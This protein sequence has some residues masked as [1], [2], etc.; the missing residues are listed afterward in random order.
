MRVSILSLLDVLRVISGVALLAVAAY[1]GWLS[2]ALLK[3]GPAGLVT[4]LWALAHD[5]KDRAGFGDVVAALAAGRTSVVVDPEFFVVTVPELTGLIEFVFIELVF[6]V[7]SLVA[8]AGLIVAR[9]GVFGLVRFPVPHPAHLIQLRPV[10]RPR[11]C[12]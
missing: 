3:P 1:A 12:D 5:G 7:T 4:L 10:Q 8:V 11:R 6:V 2:T 9:G